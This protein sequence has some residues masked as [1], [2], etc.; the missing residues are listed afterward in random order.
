LHLHGA[1]LGD[2]KEIMFQSSGFTT[3]Q[4]APVNESL[5]KAVVQIAPDCRLGEHAMR[6]RTA[7]GISEQQTFY[8]GALPNIDEKEPNNDLASAQRIPLNVTVNGVITNEDVDYFAFDAKKGQRVT[9]EIEGMRLG[10]TLF[11]PYVAI[12]DSKRFELAA[13][14]D[15]PLLGQDAVASTIIPADG[16]YYV[17]VR[18][19][20][21][22]GSDSSYY[23]L[24]V[25]T[26]PRPLATLPAGG[27]AGQEVE[28]RLLGDAAGELR[29][30]I[31]L[32]SMPSDFRLFAEDAGG[33]APSGNLLRVSEFDNVV[34][35]E[36][37][38]TH[39]QAT[40][41]TL[42]AALNG[43]IARSGEVDYFRFQAMAGTAYDIHCF[44]RRLGSPLDPVISVAHPN[45]P[46]LAAN[47][48]TFGPD[49]YIRFAPPQTK[50][51]VLAVSDHLAKGGPTYSYRIE[52]APVRPKIS[53]T[54]PKVALY[55]QE[56]QTIPVPRG[57]RYAALI[58]ATRADCAGDLVIAAE[59]LPK[60]VA[61][62]TETMVANAEVVPVLFEAAADAPLGGGLMS[63][64]GRLADPKQ[65]VP[66]EF[67]QVAELI[68]APPN[69]SVYWRHEVN[70]AAVAVTEEV[71]FRISIIEPKVPLVQ[72]GLMNLKVVAERKPGFKAPIYL[73]ML[74]NPPGTGS[75]A[76][77]IPESKTE[78]YI[79]MN[80]NSAAPI[81]TWK[82]VVQGFATVG[83]GPVCVASQLANLRVA[84]AYATIAMQRA[85]S[86][87]GKETE[88][89]C[90]VQVATPFSGPARV[91]L[92][93][94]PPQV[95]AAPVDIDQ[96]AKDFAFK[97]TVPKTAPAGTHR[98]IFCQLVVMQDG[99]PIVHYQGASELRI[100]PP[101]AQAAAPAAKSVPKP[102]TPQVKRLSRLEKL[103]E[104]QEEREKASGHGP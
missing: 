12:L 43:V 74:F 17:Q 59:G 28:I 31:K 42:P 65:S 53:L 93:G 89:P 2:A 45:G 38:H 66:S 104:E 80:A 70:R 61:V 97:V 91:Q 83:N 37:N 73:A 55:S 100:D 101:L 22:G 39:A 76:V 47:D 5:V 102:P 3:C 11:D 48:D 49:S 96:N 50:D 78:A 56:R 7:T 95:S 14:D 63:F 18:E 90:K 60:G 82:I 29:Q 69:L 92:M 87:Q 84:P 25:G 77:T 88:L 57:N 44:A 8:V 20:A 99:E 34:E 19:S 26:F 41:C 54:I 94:L 68:V 10:H 79:P 46:V 72:N 75:G 9:A 13:C 62:Q 103:R 24:H 64:T 71:P 4:L 81:R 98:N 30:K 32:P 16:T 58:S 6:L 1:R 51:Y 27:K 21:F 36:P 40:P 33:I 85:A 52:I 86:E 15:A 23:R 67:S 35:V